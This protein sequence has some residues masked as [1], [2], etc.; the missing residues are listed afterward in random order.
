MVNSD[1]KK[2]RAVQESPVPGARSRRMARLENT[3]WKQSK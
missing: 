1:D 3:W 2:A